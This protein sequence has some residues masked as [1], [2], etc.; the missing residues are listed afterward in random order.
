[1]SKKKFNYYTS[2]TASSLLLAV[3]VIAA[4]L[5]APFKSL[6]ASIFSHHWVGKAVIIPAV[7]I[8]AGFYYDKNK[9]F[10]KKIEHIAWYSTL[11]SISVIFLF[12]IIHYFA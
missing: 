1:M 12:F 6:L 2:I 9:L 8:L 3:I 7:F 11:L 10:G 5:I 4:E